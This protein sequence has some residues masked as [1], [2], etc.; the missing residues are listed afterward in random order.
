MNNQYNNFNS[1]N[2][3][4]NCGSPN[5]YYGNNN[6]SNVGN[7]SVDNNVHASV[8][9]NAQTDIGFDANYGVSNAEGTAGKKYMCRN[10]GTMH[11]GNEAPKNCCK[12]DGC[13]FREM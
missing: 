12:C 2:N 10:C 7:S 11:Y 3:P 9:N 5:K 6:V 4:S 8:N 13:N 1:N